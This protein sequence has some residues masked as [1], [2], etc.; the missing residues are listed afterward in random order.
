MTAPK[1][2]VA[3]VTGAARGIGRAIALRLAQDGIA[4]AVWDIDGPGAEETAARITDTGG[5]AQACI[6]DAADEKAMAASLEATRSALGPVT[7]LINNAAIADV[8]PFIEL[9]PD[10][11]DRFLRI[12]L[13]G[14]YLL[15][16]GVVPDMLNAGWGRIVNITSSS[17][18]T[19]A[20]GMAHYA[21]TKGGL[22]ALTKSLAMEF[23]DKGITANHVPPSFIATDM[24]NRSPEETTKAAQ[25]F[26]MKRQGTTEE[27]A[28]AAA[29]LASEEAS[30][31]T[32]QTLSV[33]GGRYSF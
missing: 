16:Q 7:I 24:T 12:N 27:V 18:Q 1:N 5:C 15:T 10:D 22:I 8:C 29:F 6:G 30:Y 25:R 2:K 4:V 26:P 14:P 20:P 33:N 28:A 23:A 19:G 11:L 3:V 31:I 9:Q 32:G 21:T 13:R 17:A